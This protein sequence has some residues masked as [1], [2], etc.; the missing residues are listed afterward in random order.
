MQPVWDSGKVLGEPIPELGPIHARG[1]RSAL[2]NTRS[3][4]SRRC[5]LAMGPLVHRNFWPPRKKKKKPH[6]PG[7]GKGM[8]NGSGRDWDCAGAAQMLF[9]RS[10]LP[11]AAA[12]SGEAPPWSSVE[13]NPLQEKVPL[14]TSGADIPPAENNKQA[15]KPGRSQTDER[16]QI[17]QAR[18]ATIRWFCCVVFIRMQFFLKGVG[19]IKFPWCSFRFGPPDPAF[20]EPEQQQPPAGWNW[21]WDAEILRDSSAFDKGWTSRLALNPCGFE[22]GCHSLVGA[23]PP[24]QKV[25]HLF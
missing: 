24:F 12:C 6:N 13:P 2:F 16:S 20:E 19:S 9:D 15:E 8:E 5:L 18:F 23:A 1:R 10:G 3:R 7:V 22:G 14:L 21:S 11:C 17:S 25:Q 4:A